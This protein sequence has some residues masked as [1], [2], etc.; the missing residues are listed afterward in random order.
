MRACSTVVLQL[1]PLPWTSSKSTAPGLNQNADAC[2]NPLTA[3][4]RAGGRDPRR[5]S[6]PPSGRGVVVR[7]TAPRWLLDCAPR[8]LRSPA[9]PPCP[10]RDRRRCS[11]WQPVGRI[12]A[13]T[14]A[15]PPEARPPCRAASVRCPARSPCAENASRLQAGHGAAPLDDQ[16][17]RLRRERLLLHRLSTVDRPKDGSLLDVGP[18]QPFAQRLDRRPDQKHPAL[19][20]GVADLGPAELDCEAQQGR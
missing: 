18:L 14:A 15:L 8:G 2:S 11:S 5:A 17:D 9:L 10:W 13:G 3:N 12:G 7:V 6:Q 16:I 19:L 4:M 1:C 20:V